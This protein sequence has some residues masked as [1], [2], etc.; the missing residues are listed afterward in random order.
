M[1]LLAVCLM[2]VA[3]PSR[4]D[5]GKPLQTLPQSA[6]AFPLPDKNEAGFILS[7]TQDGRG[8]IWAGTEDKGVWQFQ[9]QT[10][11]WR[12]FRVKDGL[13]DDN[14]Y[15]VAVDSV[16]RVWC[17]HLN[18]GVSVWNGQK[19]RNY[20]VGAGPL[21]ERITA[22]SVSPVD[23]DVWIAHNAGLTRYSEKSKT[24]NHYTRTD[25]LASTDISALTFDSLGNLYVATQTDGLLI[26]RGDDD[27]ANWTQIKAAG[28]MPDSVEGA[29]LPSNFIND[30]MVSDFDVIYAATSNGLARSQDFGASWTFL[31]G[32]DWKDKLKGL[33]EPRAPREWP[34]GFTKEL[35]REDYVTNIAEDAQGSLLLSY[36]RK[37]FEIRRPLVDR[38]TFS[39]TPEDD[40]DN[41][42][43]AYVSAILP[44]ADGTSLLGTYGDGLLHGARQPAFSPT[45]EEQRNYGNRRNWRLP[46]APTRVPELPAT[47]S[48]PTLDE[49]KNLTVRVLAA[50]A[51]EAPIAA[52]LPDDWN[53][54]GDWL[55]RYGRDWAALCAM[56]SPRDYIW[57]AGSE[58]IDYNL[59]VDPRQKDNALRYWV[60]WVSTDNPRALDWKCRRFISTA[61]WRAATPNPQIIGVN[62]KWTT[63]AKLIP[64]GKRGQM[65]TRR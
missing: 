50:P 17:G 46:P 40:A 22:I 61:A 44:L 63:T 18:H 56:L 65:F 8:D 31:R 62:R 30:V 21:G 38:M 39:S 57:G 64:Y 47:A 54:Q 11:K 10:Q 9:S 43:F 26:G 51:S 58:K 37:G 2:A 3:A 55:G 12:N 32:R 52:A 16:G 33:Y 27:Y 60:H 28:A 34:D 13:G 23:G 41:A 6:E 14:A 35:L 53:T 49:L 7:L 36:R 15:A 25:G 1:A 24:W 42:S 48:A 29:G 59:R 45:A 4:G 20:P 19:W 5:D